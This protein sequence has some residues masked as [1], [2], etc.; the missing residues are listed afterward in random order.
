VI[1]FVDNNGSKDSIVKGHSFSRAGDDIVRA[2]IT[3]E[4]EQCSW[5]WYARVPT[6]SNPADD[7]SRLDTRKLDEEGIFTRVF[8]VQPLSF[9][10]GVA[11]FAPVQSTMQ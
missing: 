3:L 6:H 10:G 2:V 11:V 7:P 5:N 1:F 4:Y 9:A 8:I